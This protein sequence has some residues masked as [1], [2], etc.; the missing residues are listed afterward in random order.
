MQ[1][2]RREFSEKGESRHALE[3]RTMAYGY[4]EDSETK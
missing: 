1:C 4:P 3:V 2:G